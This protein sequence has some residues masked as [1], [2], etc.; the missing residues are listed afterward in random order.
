MNDRY[1]LHDR[2]E[3]DPLLGRSGRRIEQD[4]PG[5]SPPNSAEQGP[6]EPKADPGKRSNQSEGQ[7]DTQ[8]GKYRTDKDGHGKSHESQTDK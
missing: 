3:Y 2:L 5:A 4:E 8:H 6:A 1:I 7:Q